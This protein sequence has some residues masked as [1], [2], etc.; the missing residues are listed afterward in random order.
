MPTSIIF[1]CL[2]ARFNFKSFDVHA[3]CWDKEWELHTAHQDIPLTTE[4]IS[5]SG[6]M[7]QGIGATAERTGTKHNYCLSTTHTITWS[8]GQ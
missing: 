7:M 1:E 4:F 5:F 6:N 3:G 2:Y 8:Q